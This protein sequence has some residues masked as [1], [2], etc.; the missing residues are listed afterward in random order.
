MLSRQARIILQMKEM[1]AQGKSRSD[2]Q[3]KLGLTSDWVLRKAWEQADRYSP[4]RLRELYHRLLETDISIKTGRMDGEI[5]LNILITEL[6][7]R[8]TVSA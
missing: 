4:S 1:R 7:Q 2:I 3:S 6:G 5:A 8:G